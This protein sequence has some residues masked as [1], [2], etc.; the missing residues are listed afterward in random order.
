MKAATRLALAFGLMATFLVGLLVYHVRTIGAAAATNYELSEISAR[1]ALGSGRLPAHLA[2]LDETASKYWITRDSGY[3]RQ[4]DEAAQAFDDG[5]RRLGAYAVGDAE[6]EAIDQLA[7]LWAEFA[8]AA[9]ALRPSPAGPAQRLGQAP[10]VRLAE[11]VD[12][13]RAQTRLVAFAAQA[14]MDE[15]LERS[16]AAARHAA[17]ITWGTVVGALL[18]GI[19]VSGLVV[20]SISDA[21]R[22]LQEGTR[23]VAGGN[24][25]YRL[26]EGRSDEFAEL[27][28]DFNTM[29]RRLGE[30]DRMKRDFLSKVSHDLKT[31]LASMQETT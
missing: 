11:H 2:R 20:R 19:L 6:R 26:D 18:L 13:R 24:F 5:V 14:Q 27:A 22:R 1:I 15:R 17:R 25:E 7:S 23:Q 30:L 12:R 10:L 3:L 9:E 8:P 29:T 21:L 31:P 28:R 16:A 4:F